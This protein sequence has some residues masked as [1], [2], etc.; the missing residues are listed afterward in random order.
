MIT[1]SQE[2][3]RAR[4]ELDFKAF[5][6]PKSLETLSSCRVEP[7]LGSAE[8]GSRYQFER[9]GYFCADVV[10]SRKDHL[11]FNRTV[12]LRDEWAKIQKEQAKSPD[13]EGLADRKRRCG[14]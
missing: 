12:T 3:T 9:I 14:T 13:Q 10:D 7:S 5:L 8:P 1:C 6:N 11:V 4:K 2:P